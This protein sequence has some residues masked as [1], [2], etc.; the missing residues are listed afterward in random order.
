M[1]IKSKIIKCMKNHYSDVIARNIRNNYEKMM[2]EF[3]VLEYLD[4]VFLYKIQEPY[5]IFSGYRG[6]KNKGLYLIKGLKFIEDYANKK[7]LSFVITNSDS[8]SMT[9]VLLRLGYKQKNEKEL[10]KCVIQ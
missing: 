4:G 9:K 5:L 1:S 3:E 7:N 6:E 8:K 10:I 2:Q